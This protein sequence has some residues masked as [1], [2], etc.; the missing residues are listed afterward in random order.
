MRIPCLMLLVGLSQWCS[1]WGVRRLLPLVLPPTDFVKFQRNCLNIVYNSWGR[2]APPYSRIILTLIN[3]WIQR[4]CWG[5]SQVPQVFLKLCWGSST[6]ASDAPQRQ[7]LRRS[8]CKKCV[9]GGALWPRALLLQVKDQSR[10]ERQ[11]GE[12]GSWGGRGRMRGR[13]EGRREAA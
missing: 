1:C 12:A 4:W 7:M 11:L 8:W 6:G 3:S 5:G 13:S 9:R 10:R 2:K